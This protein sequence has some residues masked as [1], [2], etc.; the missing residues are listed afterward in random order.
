MGIWSY[1]AYFSILDIVWE[2]IFP[3]DKSYKGPSF[4]NLKQFYFN[5]RQIQ[6]LQQMAYNHSVQAQ[7][8]RSV[9]DIAGDAKQSK[10]HH[11]LEMDDAA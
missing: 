10:V 4:S 1:P 9:A 6:T 8:K 11:I 3:K 5:S 2:K 7:K